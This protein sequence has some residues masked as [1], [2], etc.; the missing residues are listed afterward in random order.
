[1]SC[2]VCFLYTSWIAELN[3]DAIKISFKA[4]LSATETLVLV[5]KAY[6]SEALNQSKVFGWYSWFQDRRELV[7]DGERGG[8]P[9]STQTELNLSIV[10]ADLVN[11]D[12]R[13]T[14]RMI[15]ESLNIPRTLVLQILKKDFCCQDFSFCKIMCPPPHKAASVSQFFYVTALYHPLQSADLSLCQT[16]FS[17]P[18]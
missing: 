11:N 1:L 2:E 18:S 15:A 3:R 7:E 6:G 12:H 14:S 17:S 4:G 8:C 5:E 13:I 10:A 16:I 9:K